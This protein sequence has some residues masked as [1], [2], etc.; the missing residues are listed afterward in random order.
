[1]RKKSRLGYVITRSDLSLNGN[2]NGLIKRAYEKAAT[3]QNAANVFVK[4]G[5][6]QL[7][8][9]YSEMLILKYIQS[10]PQLMSPKVKFYS[11]VS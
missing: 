7:I 9:I 11:V 3:V 10:Y 8:D 6:L 2:I 4:Q 1:M 5:Y